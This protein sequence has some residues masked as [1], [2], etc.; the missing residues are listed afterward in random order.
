[1]TKYA[2]RTETVEYYNSNDGKYVT[3]EELLKRIANG[4]KVTRHSSLGTQ[5]DSL[6]DI[7]ILQRAAELQGRGYDFDDSDTRIVTKTIVKIEEVT[8]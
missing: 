2:I 4:D 8:D 7:K 6:E 5:V 3:R 1:M